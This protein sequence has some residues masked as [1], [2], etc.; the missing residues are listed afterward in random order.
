LSAPLIVS[1]VYAH[2]AQSQDGVYIYDLSGSSNPI[3]KADVLLTAFFGFTTAV[4]MLIASF[5]LVS[6]MY[7]NIYE[8]TKEIG[9][10]SLS[11]S[12][13]PCTCMHACA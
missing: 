6:S 8:Q 1:F 9:T 3:Q 2:D 7:T 10:L 5:S 12:L 4:A 11:L 13:P